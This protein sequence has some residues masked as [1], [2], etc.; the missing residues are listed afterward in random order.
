[1]INEQQWLEVVSG[2]LQFNRLVT[3]D[4][5]RKSEEYIIKCMN[6][7]DEELDEY[8]NCWIKSTEE[9]KEMCDVIVVTVQLIDAITPSKL[10]YEL[11]A[12]VVKA[13]RDSE[14]GYTEGSTHFMSLI[15]GIINVAEVQAY[16]LY[17][18]M[19]AVNKSN[20]SKVVYIPTLEESFGEHWALGAYKLVGDLTKEYEGRYTGINYTKVGDYLVFRDDKLKV[21]K[22]KSFYQ[23]PDLKPFI[24][25]TGE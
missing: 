9:L 7:M 14:H 20:M 8:Y 5:E 23:D 22:P 17:G 13:Y 6:L 12:K 4:Q 18:A 19:M 24:N 11:L 2:I 10:S 21:L 15:A 3:T 1:M 25:K 16:D